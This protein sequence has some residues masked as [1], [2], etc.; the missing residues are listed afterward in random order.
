MIN[1]L[2]RTAVLSATCFVASIYS[3]YA[4]DVTYKDKQNYRFERQNSS[5]C[6]RYFSIYEHKHHMPSNMLRAI[7]VTESGK[8]SHFYHKK[9]AWPW[10][11]NVEGKGYY[12]KSRQDAIAKVR[13]LQSQGKESIDIGCMQIN[14]KYHPDAFT[15]LNQA[16]EPRYNIAYAAKFLTQ[17]YKRNRNWETAIRH[18]HSKNRE[19]SDKYIARIYDAWRREDK[20]VNLATLKNREM[21]IKISPKIKNKD[22]EVA[23]ITQNV[24]DRFV[25]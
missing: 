14:L 3:A 24:L 17:K 6:N 15:N 23:E 11:I 19:F 8:W 10:T 4:N 22:P 13:E 25:R 16:F 9:V 2:S 21:Y 1:N 12:F 18:Y 20:G 7:S 5:L